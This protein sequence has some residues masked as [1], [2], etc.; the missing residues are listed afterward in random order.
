MLS[1]RR[2]GVAVN[3]EQAVDDAVARSREGSFV[4]RVAREVTGGRVSADVQPRVV[5]SRLAVA[6]FVAQ[7]GD[8]FDRRRATR[9]SPSRR[10]RSSR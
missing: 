4:S 3:V 7:V 2:A 10:R 9:A 6:H 1:A 8:G 5:Y